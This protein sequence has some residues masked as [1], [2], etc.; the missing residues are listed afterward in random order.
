MSRSIKWALALASVLLFA[1][2]VIPLG[3]MTRPV[4]ASGATEPDFFVSKQDSNVALNKVAPWVLENTSDGKTA[5]FLVVL[6]EQAD[7]SGAELFKTKA[8]KGR[9]VYETLYRNATQTQQPMLDWLKA[10]GIEHRSYYIVNLIW[11]RGDRNVVTALAE[12]PEVKRLEG[13]PRI[14][15]VPDEPAKPAPK[16]GNAPEAIEPG[17]TFIHAPEVWAAGFTGQGMVVGA[18]DTGYRWDHNAIKGKY[19]GWDG[20]TANHNYNWHDS[21]HSGGGTCGANTTAPCDDHGHGT[22]TAGTVLGDDGGTNQVGVAPGAKWI[23]CR[24]MDQGNGT[25]ATYLE[26]MEFFVAPYPVGGTPAQGDPLKSPDITTNSWG[27]PASEGCSVNTLQA[28]VEAQRAAGIIMVVAA[29][30]SGS[31]CST[32]S[33]PPSFYDAAYTVG[34]FS[35]STGTIASFSSRGGTLPD[36]S[37]RVKPDISAPGVS[38][39]SATNSSTT[40]YASMSGTSMATPHTAGAMALLLSALPSLRDNVTDAEGYLNDTAVRVSSTACG[41]VANVYPNNTYGYGRLDIKAAVDLARTTASPSPSTFT[42]A[43][44]PGSITVDAPTAT[45]NWSATTS[46]SWITN[47]TP[48]GTGDGSVTFTVAP[49]TSEKSRRGTI[50]VARK[51]VTIIQAGAGMPIAVYRPSEGNWLTRGAGGNNTIQ[52]WG[53]AGDQIVP[54]DYDGDGKTDIGVF[55]PSEGNWYI[56]RSSDGTILL[57]NWGQTGDVPVPGDYD[58]D[59]KTD[60]A[61]FRPNEGNWYVLR[62]AGG[63]I[64][65]GWGTNT[66]KPVV[67]DFDNDGRTDFTVYRPSEGNW[68]VRKSGGGVTIKN[69]GL[70]ADKPVPADYDGDGATDFAVW[71]SGDWYIINS[72]SGTVTL[73][74][75]GNPSDVPVPADYEGDGKADVAIWRGSEGN[76]YIIQ[77]STNT[78]NLINFGLGGDVPVPSANMPQ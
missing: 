41:S 65:Q 44:G 8:E 15:N 3:R 76:W 49:N 54:G 69:W 46:A 50:T 11:V 47:L 66:D 52:Q 10:S 7:L 78:V 77:S 68:Y 34:A 42:A 14:K 53:T 45:V 29:G 24:N 36:G 2:V 13:N 37:T 22:H 6:N 72:S 31:S 48:S 62:N 33:D 35:S 43:G 71:R 70:A 21:V 55:R 40:A 56:V 28:G 51:V 4:E 74:N 30:N 73:K 25:P 5:E 20:A 19:R 61:I 38:V 59:G 58:A 16:R 67:G 1:L 26:C 63:V 23:G 9:Y 27:C 39:R 12:R 75:W 60:F 17:V 32:V 57:R 64:M 18:A